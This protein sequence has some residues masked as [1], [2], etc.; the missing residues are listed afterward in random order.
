MLHQPKR[1]LSYSKYINYFKN[2]A[3][4]IKNNK[5]IKYY[6]Y[7]KK[8]KY[9]INTLSNITILDL[10][11]ISEQKDLTKLNAYLGYFRTY[12]NYINLYNQNLEIIENNQHIFHKPK[13]L[14]LNHIDIK[15]H[16]HFHNITNYNNT[17]M[18]SINVDNTQLKIFKNIINSIQYIKHIN[19]IDIY[20]PILEDIC[21]PKKYIINLPNILDKNEAQNLINLINN[22]IIM[23]DKYYK[24]NPIKYSHYWEFYFQNIKDEDLLFICQY[25]VNYNFIPHELENKYNFK[26]YVKYNDVT[27]FSKYNAFLDVY[28]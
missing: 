25:I 11:D 23:L 20:E 19:Y 18:Y 4:I 12:D 6:E 1:L 13:L 22:N 9:I 28:V 27:K 15:Y 2:E 8:S 5:N 7:N 24:L 14:T 10:H 16:S 17:K 26:F 21:I 3:N